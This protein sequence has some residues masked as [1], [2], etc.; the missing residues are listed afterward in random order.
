MTDK[1]ASADLALIFTGHMVDAPDRESPRFPPALEPSVTAAIRE[2]VAAALGDAAGPVLAI[3]SGAR[4]G[5]ILFLEACQAAGLA[6]VVVLPSRP[7]VF[8]EKSVRGA[9]SGDWE[10]RFGQVWAGAAERRVVPVPADA[11]P[12]DVCN[13]EMRQLARAR[14]RRQRL[15]ALWDG[16]G[17]DGP[18]GTADFVRL[19]E[20]AGGEW[21]HLDTRPLLAR[22]P[23]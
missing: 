8:V 16:G 23:G 15:L 14:A 11:N 21:R 5:D 6:S 12:Y 9:A 7:E 1:S 18:G 20:E 22:I 3:A 2:A 4:G 13:R 10:H 17:G 19:V